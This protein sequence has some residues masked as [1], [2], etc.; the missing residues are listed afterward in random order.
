MTQYPESP[1]NNYNFNEFPDPENNNMSIMV[2]GYPINHIIDDNTRQSGGGDDRLKHLSVPLGLVMNYYGGDSNLHGK[3][4]KTQYKDEN[5][6]Q[7]QDQNIDSRNKNND[8][9]DDELFKKLFGNVEQQNVEHKHKKST[10]VKI[11][12]KTLTPNKVRKTKK[13]RSK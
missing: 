9:A 1:L 10:T 2:G 5:K 3:Y 11:R 13:H 12:E 4:N 6:D 7:D 8:P